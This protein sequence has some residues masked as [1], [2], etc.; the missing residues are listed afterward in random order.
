MSTDLVSRARGL[1]AEATPG[2]WHNLAA[3]VLASSFNELDDEPITIAD[4]DCDVRIDDEQAQRNATLIAAAPELLAQMAD[5]IER[6]RAER[7]ELNAVID[8]LEKVIDDRAAI[9]GDAP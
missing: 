7:D 2:P 9:Q 1:V 8:H 5:E 4:Y 3:R 6:L